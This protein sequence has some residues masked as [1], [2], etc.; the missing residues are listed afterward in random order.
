MVMVSSN[1]AI[2]SAPPSWRIR[3]IAT[4]DELVNEGRGEGRVTADHV[5]VVVEADDLH[6]GDAVP[7]EE[8]E[9]DRLQ[10]RQQHGAAEEQEG[11]RE[12]EGDR[13]S[14]SIGKQG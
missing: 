13:P 12:E 1:E 7:L 5:R 10:N 3:Q 6:I 14:G 2:S 8:R 9:V 11:R 4:I